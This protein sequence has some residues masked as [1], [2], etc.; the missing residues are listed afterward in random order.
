MHHST[1]RPAF[2]SPLPRLLPHP[3]IPL[4]STNINSSLRHS[5]GKPP[6]P[7]HPTR[8][9]RRQSKPH[10]AWLTGNSQSDF[11]TL[12]SAHSASPNIHRV[13]GPYSNV[14]SY[15]KSIG[16]RVI[17]ASRAHA[18]A[19][20]TQFLS[21]G[22]SLCFSDSAAPIFT[23]SASP[24]LYAGALTAA[25]PVLQESC[26]DAITSF[27]AR[28]DGKLQREVVHD[29]RSILQRF[30]A[31]MV[32]VYLPQGFPL[33]TTPDY[34][35]FTK[36]RTIQ[37]LASAIMQVISTEALLFGLGLG[38][39][40][41]AG[42]AAT[43]WVL[44]DGASYLVKIGYG[45][46]FGSKFDDDPKSWRIAADIVEDVGGAIEILTPLFPLTYFLP[47]ASLAV[48]LRGMSL[49]T[50]T[51]TRHVVYRSLAASGMQNTGD[52]A[53][54]G[55]SQGVTMKM[56]GLATGILVSNRIGQNYYALLAAYTALA[57][58]HIVAN[59]RSVQCVQFSFFNKQRA[60]ILIQ[61]HLNGEAL[62]SPYDVSKS[63][64][65]VLPPWRGFEPSVKIGG[66]VADAVS[67]AEQ[68]KSTVK[69]FRGER[70]LIF[71]ENEGKKIRVLLRHNA[72]SKDALRAYY[73]IKKYMHSNN[74][75]EVELREAYQFM[76]RNIRYFEKKAAKAGWD[77]R[78]M[79]LT[80][81]RTRI[82]W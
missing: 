43:S 57:G 44:K 8:I 78:H 74:R 51:A 12:R 72:T 65:I 53:T 47:L 70:F 22:L 69:M 40:V 82:T 54:K 49:M 67:S 56:I 42:A 38:K 58:V 5:F 3:P 60:S 16:A 10:I 64:G 79:L 15:A 59:W 61:S 76:R 46:V 36:Y 26:D 17:H 28:E 32:R 19:Y 62:P 75:S 13:T 71:A 55:E 24:L 7:R 45:S 9:R 39:T 21:A 20:L 25:I 37:N 41:A 11:A 1:P 66:R 2:I 50:G 77:M 6:T 27:F 52:I 48:C 14:I 34:I 81:G 73:V 18:A 35:S 63:E 29:D 33:T 23:T 4:T 30:T 68:L 80:D 31:W